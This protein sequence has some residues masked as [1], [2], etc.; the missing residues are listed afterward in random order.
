[1]PGIRNVSAD[2]AWVEGLKCRDPDI[3]A[4]VYRAY[5]KPVYAMALQVLGHKETAED[6]TSEVFIDVL[7]KAES[8]RDPNAL[9]GWIQRITINRCR[10]LMRSTAYKQA[11]NVVDI[12]ELDLAD[13]KPTQA[14]EIDIEQLFAQL[15]SAMRMVVW[16]FCVEGLSHEEVGAWMGR[17][18]SYSK[19]VVH[20]AKLLFAKNPQTLSKKHAV[21]QKNANGR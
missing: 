2:P 19:S 4:Q 13:P 10:M 16:L 7:T 15:P 5:N 21:M 12:T 1:M 14:L 20:R 6:V 9:T 17:T 11:N 3:Q 8:I 18:T